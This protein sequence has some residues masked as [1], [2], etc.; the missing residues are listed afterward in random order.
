LHDRKR[1]RCRV[2]TQRGLRLWAVRLLS[3]GHEATVPRDTHIGW[4]KR[5]SGI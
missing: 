2:E 1:V 4:W 3:R 5:S